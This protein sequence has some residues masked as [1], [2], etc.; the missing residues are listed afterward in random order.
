MDTNPDVDPEFTVICCPDSFKG[1][2][3]ADEASEAMAAGVR[4]AGAK[5]VTVPMAD[6]GEGTA[7]LLA[8]AWAVDE[9]VAHDVD[10]VDAIGRPITARW[11]E[12]TPERAV[13]DLASASGLPAVADSPD[14]LGASTFGTGEVI[15]D[16]LDHGATDLTLCL[17]GSATTDGGAGI[18]VALGGRIVDASGR[19][20]PRGG[21]ALAGADRLDLTGLDPR[22]RRATWTLVL[23]VTTPPRDAPAVFGPQKG[24]TPEQ[25]RH[26]TKALVNWCRIC[27]VDPDQAGYGAAGATPVGISAVAGASLSIEG[28]AALL[29]RATGLDEA[30]SAASCDL[31]LTGEGSVDA[32]SHVGKVVGWVVDHAGAPVHVIGGVVDEE[33]VVVKH[34]TGTTALPGPMEHTCKQLRAAA[35]EATVRAARKAWRARRP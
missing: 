26:L 14:A 20:A 18:V 29:G 5:A 19:A 27:G 35:Y 31:I 2:A 17:G 1:T 21:G 28:G 32:Q 23:D 30:M 10:V 6:G 33:A 7:E 22:A 9:A 3:T 4:D 16:A 8:R 15:L 34:A 24:A 25:V 12:P 11:W 13:L